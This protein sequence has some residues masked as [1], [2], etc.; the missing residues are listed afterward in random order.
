MEAARRISATVQLAAQE[1]RLAFSGSQLVNLAEWEEARLFVSGALTAAAQLPEPVARDAAARLDLAARL[2][3]G[4]ASPDSVA[5][6]AAALERMLATAFG[7]AMDDRASRAPSLRAGERIYAANCA[8]CHG[9][10]GRGDGPAASQLDPRPAD[11]GDS[12]LLATSTP[13][14]FY[15]RITHGV[16]GTAMPS[17]S[18]TLSRDERWDA[19]AWVFAL[20][21]RVAKDAGDGRLA[22]VFGAVRGHL[23]S[24]MELA[25]AGEADRAAGR[26][27]ESYMAF[28]EIEA[29]LG[30]TNPRLRARSERLFGE[31]RDA[32]AAGRPEAERERLYVQLAEAVREAEGALVVRRSPVG[33]FA[34]SLLLMLREGFEAILVIGAIMAVLLKAGA[35]Q[36]RRHVRWGIA[37]AVAA[38]AVTAAA[39]EW[40]FHISPAQ[41]EALEGGVML[42]A[43]A[44]LFYVSYWL[45]SKVEIAAWTRFV[46]G[47]IQRAVAS[48]SALTLAGVAFLAVYR[49]GFETVLFYK[50]LFVTAGGSGAGA[51]IAGMALGLALLA[52]VYVGIERFG[53]RIPMRPFFAVTGATLA[54]MAFVFAGN[55]VRELQDGGFVGATPVAGVPT[56]TFLGIYPTVETLTI[57]GVILLAILGALAFTFLVQPRRLAAAAREEQPAGPA[58]ARATVE[59]ETAAV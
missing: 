50:A 12:V 28:E 24:A 1:Y 55:G 17:F 43:A 36:G 53:L 21:D 27:L 42:L 34:E 56:S 51:I 13:L 25:R 23:G 15:R 19:V 3:E 45:I 14:D 49:E 30:A 39:I 18:G 32:I 52:G 11:L 2:I 7:V 47:K 33:L 5:A 37:A 31:L 8:S 38:S 54:Y 57:Q 22:V 46:K 59:E 6:L 4:R 35:A 26:L 9:L 41:Q 29:M 48:G 40:I 44:V 16:P 20:Q 58:P 10:R